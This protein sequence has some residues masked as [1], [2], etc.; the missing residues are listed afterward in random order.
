[1]TQLCLKM[2][3][4]QLDTVQDS[5]ESS[6]TLSALFEKLFLLT[7]GAKMFRYPS[8]TPVLHL[9]SH[10]SWI[11]SPVSCFMSLVSCLLSHVSCLLSSVTSNVSCLLS[12]VSH[13]LSPVSSLLVHVSCLKSTVYCYTIKFQFLCPILKRTNELMYPRKI[14]R[15]PDRPHIRDKFSFQVRAFYISTY[16]LPTIQNH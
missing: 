8:Q 16:C 14:S 12:P 10:V 1:M 2:S 15:I 4:V 6:W 11:M 5:P 9:L 3:W 13:L 7:G